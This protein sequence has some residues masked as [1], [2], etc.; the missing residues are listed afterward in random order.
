VDNQLHLRLAATGTMLMKIYAIQGQLVAQ[1]S[2]EFADNQSHVFLGQLA[3]G[4]YY[5]ELWWPDGRSAM[6][7]RVLKK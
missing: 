2:I 4:W 3:A 7:G 1:Q 6:Q 5:F